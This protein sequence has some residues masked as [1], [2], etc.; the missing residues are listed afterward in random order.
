M[1]MS[2]GSVAV[3]GALCLWGCVT[4]P[5]IPKDLRGNGAIILGFTTDETMPYEG[6]TLNTGFRVNRLDGKAVNLGKY[7]VVLVEPGHHEIK[8]HCYWRL[9]RISLDIDDLLEPA[10]LTLNVE[11]NTHY[12][13]Q[14]E[15]DEYKTKCKLRVIETPVAEQAANPP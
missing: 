13:I 6:G 9:H 3:F 1:G 15:I 4:G 5:Q 10:Q 7:D 14:S 8:G 12:T 2:Y 11:A